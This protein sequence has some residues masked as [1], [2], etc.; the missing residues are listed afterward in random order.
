MPPAA[1]CSVR[2]HP[3]MRPRP[4]EAAHKLRAIRKS[5]RGA[6][7]A[8]LEEAALENSPENLDEDQRHRGVAGQARDGE[9]PGGDHR[10]PRHGELSGFLISWA[11]PA[12]NCPSE[13]IFSAWISRSWARRA[14][15]VPETAARSRWR[16]RPA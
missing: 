16:A 4:T 9:L 15:P 7:H 6:R 13:A 11:M 3:T 8:N 12:V 2:P 5:G 10:T 1:T 14:G